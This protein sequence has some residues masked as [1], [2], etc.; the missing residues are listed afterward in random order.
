MAVALFSEHRQAYGV[1]RT[2][3]NRHCPAW[4]STAVAGSPPGCYG[5][6]RTTEEPIAA[7]LRGVEPQALRVT[8]QPSSEVGRALS[9][10]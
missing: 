8:L 4:T 9:G 1:S 10:G 6:R 3:F 2:F 7:W 5:V